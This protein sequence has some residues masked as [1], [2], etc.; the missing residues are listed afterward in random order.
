MDTPLEQKIVVGQRSFASGHR[1]VGGEEEDRNNLGRN[2]E[3]DMAVD[4][5]YWRLR[6]DVWLLAV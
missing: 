6:V 5:H 4:R 2:M 1:T 3:E